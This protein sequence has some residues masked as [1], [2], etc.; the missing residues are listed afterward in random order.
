MVDAIRAVYGGRRYLSPNITEVTFDS[1][2]HLTA[3]AGNPLELLSAREREVLQL[4][5]EGKSSAEIGGILSLSTKTVETYRVRLM[6]KL[7]LRDLPAL[8]RFAIQHGLTP[9]Q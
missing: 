1:L 2:G 3:E 6:R 4:V 8:I 7:N 5:V 9:S